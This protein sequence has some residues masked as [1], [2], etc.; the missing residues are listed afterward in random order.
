MLQVGYYLKQLSGDL[1]IMLCNASAEYKFGRKGVQVKNIQI[2]HV[3][4]VVLAN[5]CVG[6]KPDT[7][8]S[9]GTFEV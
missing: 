1:P 5:L 9:Y 3:S 4:V 6:I 7:F 8:G 2:L